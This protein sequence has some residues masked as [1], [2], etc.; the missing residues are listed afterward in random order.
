MTDLRGVWTPAAETEIQGVIVEFCG[1]RAEVEANRKGSRRLDS[2]AGNIEVTVGRQE[3]KHRKT[4][5]DVQFT[6]RDWQA[7]STEVTQTQDTRA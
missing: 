7:I 3:E 6:N 2:S 1:V 4:D 5:I